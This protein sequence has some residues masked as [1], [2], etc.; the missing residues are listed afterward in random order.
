MKHKQI[1][2]TPDSSQE[3]YAGIFVWTV[4][5]RVLFKSIH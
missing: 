1:K 4:R 3:E 5:K 2:A